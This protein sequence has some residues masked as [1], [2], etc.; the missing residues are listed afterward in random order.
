M[1]TEYFGHLDWKKRE[2]DPPELLITAGG[3]V[4]VDGV[5]VKLVWYADTA[6]G[7]AKT[8]DV[9][10]DG[11]PHATQEAFDPG[12]VQA[13]LRDAEER[14]QESWDQPLGGV[15]SKTLHGKVRIFG[16]EIEG[17]KA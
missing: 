8:Y 4:L 15:L 14:G 17:L 3:M 12:V 11:K 7:V 6:E 9:L 5:E 16:P 2:F 10:G 13:A 1:R